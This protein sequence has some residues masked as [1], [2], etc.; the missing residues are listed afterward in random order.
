VI[1]IIGILSGIMIS[2]IDPMRQQHR[3]HD[4][5]VQSTINKVALATQSFISVYGR[6]PADDEFLGGI[7][8]GTD[9][10]VDPMSTCNLADG[11][12]TVCAFSIGGNNLPDNCADD[13]RGSGAVQCN[14]RYYREDPLG[15]GTPHPT[16]FRIYAKS[17]GITNTVFVYDNMYGSSAECDSS[18][19]IDVN[20]GSATSCPNIFDADGVCL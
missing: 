19:V 14:F 20:C 7:Q 3:A 10:G 11:D 12:T 16:H 5:N 1:I 4:A 17:F 13:F 6:A 9:T 18:T 8:N 15:A 2:I